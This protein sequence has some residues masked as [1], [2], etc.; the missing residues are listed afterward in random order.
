MARVEGIGP[1]LMT[2]TTKVAS[3][4]LQSHPHAK[5]EVVLKGL[6]SASLNAMG[7]QA[8][9]SRSGHPTIDYGQTYVYQ[10]VLRLG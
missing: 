1:A 5:P 3:A 6:F 2:R 8:Q 10:L 9:V 4:V 7:M